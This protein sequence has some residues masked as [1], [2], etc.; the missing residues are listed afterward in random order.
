MARV[1]RTTAGRTLP[2]GAG[3]GLPDAPR[4]VCCSLLE[5]LAVRQC[6][7]RA[8]PHLHPLP[9]KRLLCVGCAVGAQVVMWPPGK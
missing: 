2:A 1:A 5:V 9:G 8:V 6:G 7:L 4:S 3:L